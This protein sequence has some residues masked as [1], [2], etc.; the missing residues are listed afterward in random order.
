MP[1]AL[2]DTAV[3]QPSPAAEPSS[4]EVEAPA[5][6]SDMPLPPLSS[7]PVV[8]ADVASG[9]SVGAPD[10]VPEV[11]R[12]L[13]EQG[14]FEAP[15]GWVPPDEAAA[16]RR[17][18]R[19][20]PNPDGTAALEKWTPSKDVVRPGQ[21][22][23]R[24]MSVLWVVGVLLVVGGYFG[25]RYWIDQRHAK[26][27]RL[28]AES[29]AHALRGDHR[30]LIDAERKLRF[31][32][33]LHPQAAE[34]MKTLLFVQSERALEE[35]SFEPGFMRPTL[36]RADADGLKAPE[37][38]AAKAV[39]AQADGDISGA[40]KFIEAARNASPKDGRIL[41]IAGRLEQRLGD[42]AA[43]E[44]LEA[45]MKGSPAPTAAAIAYAES[46]AD[47]GRSED[48]MRVLDQVLASN[49]GHLRA[50][51][52]R[53]LI[54][55]ADED[56]DAAL[57]RLDGLVKH[58]DVGAPTDRVL[59]GL[60]R[61]RLLRRKNDAAGATA[62][63]DEAVKAG[64][65]EPRLLGLVAEAARSLGL[66]TRAQAAAMDAVA[67]APM[68]PDFRKLLAGILLER[69][70]GVRALR[71]LEG[72]STDDPTVLT[73]SA[74]AA[75]LVGT[76]KLLQQASETL[77]AYID[78]HD[79]ANVEMQ[80]LALRQA[81]ALG[82]ADTALVRARTL[83]KASP[84]DPAALLALG[85]VA[86]AAHQA[87]EAKAA[88]ADLVNLAPSDADAHYLLG[89]AQRLARD[90]GAAEASFR[91][92]MEL[93][94]TH[95]GARSAL[96]RL[97]VEAGKYEEADKLYE[98]LAREVG[99]VE[100]ADNVVIGRLGRAEALL[101]L[102]RVT[103]ARS[104]VDSLTEE[105]RKFESVKLMSAAIS[106][107]EG[108]PGEAVVLLRPLAEAEGA[109][110]E[111]IV[112]YG[113]ALAEAGQTDVANQQF[114]RALAIDAAFPEALVGK[115]NAAV[116]AERPKDAHKYLDAAEVALETRVRP[117][118]L[119]AELYTLRGRAFI[120]EGRPKVEAARAVL[121]Q[122]VNTPGVPNDAY[123]FLGESLSA[124]NSPEAF[125]AY[126]KYLELEP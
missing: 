31:A 59:A 69:R 67:R 17:S 83:R 20:P 19:P 118:R 74:R 103:D 116:R 88:L 75:L 7:P 34:T 96:G 30:D 93:S 1:S 76:E 61:A 77:S 51:L 29:V 108:K 122:A 52:W 27:T 4:V 101:G 119:K 123:F 66:V 43:P 79:D 114:D 111:T 6:P 15:D 24:S 18:H 12:L 107:A 2:L 41:Y 38:D 48:A 100:G 53:A 71:H 78:K 33:D 102:G 10:A 73:M 104:Q 46:L 90:L 97:L 60:T 22:M 47:D 62:A 3:E 109:A 49:R 32:R 121:R 11:L 13:G 57:G 28:I 120:L 45:A 50:S 91:K 94:P 5:F 125:D 117:D 92:A 95:V 21:R 44:D 86:L 110:A 115:A 124:A 39:V 70:D 98:A 40:K 80:A 126:A 106:V 26:A 113:N 36:A 112:L 82:Q 105:Q 64:A 42:A 25:S 35:G 99:S 68:N 72:L 23:A 81:A 65:Q 54:A 63:V 37:L 87:A 8:A 89:R 9:A 55:A 84:E 56:A 58:L 16:G 14:V 85:D